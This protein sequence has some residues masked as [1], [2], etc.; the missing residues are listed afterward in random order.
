MQFRDHAHFALAFSRRLTD[1]LLAEFKTRDDL[2]FQVHPKANHALWI[3]GH[4]AIADNTFI[5]RFRP[6]MAEK[7]DGWDA[8]FWFG[9]QVTSDSS[10]YPQETEVLAYFRDRRAALLRVLDEVSDDELTGPAPPA[11]ARSPIAGAPNIGH[12]FL[13]ASTHEAMHAGQL[14]VAHRALGNAPLIGR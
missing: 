12:L 6:P 1:G 5:N 14:T 13:F 3:A 7:P 11:G 4:L 2:L 10:A 8:M 9:S